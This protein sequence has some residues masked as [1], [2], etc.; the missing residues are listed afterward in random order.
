MPIF[1]QIFNCELC[2]WKV[3][4]KINHLSVDNEGW[5]RNY[6]EGGFKSNIL[7]QAFEIKMLIENWSGLLFPSIKTN[8]QC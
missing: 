5:L 7:K 1:L 3:Q 4:K 8:L 6:W 2:P